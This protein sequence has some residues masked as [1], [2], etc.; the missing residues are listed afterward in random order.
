[1]SFLTSLRHPYD[2]LSNNLQTTNYVSKIFLRI[3]L[4]N[5]VIKFCSTCDLKLCIHDVI[6]YPYYGISSDDSYHYQML[7]TNN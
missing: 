1:M 2:N 4:L 5:C 7:L 3:F 6:S